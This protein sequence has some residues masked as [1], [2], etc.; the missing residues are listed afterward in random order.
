MVRRLIGE[1]IE[2]DFKPDPMLG[3]CRADPA[4]MEQVLINLAVNARDAM[5]GGGN[6]TIRTSNV[7]RNGEDGPEE[8][9]LVSV[10]DTGHG[11][12]EDTRA[13]IFEPFFTTKAQGKGTG[14]GLATVYG[15]VKQL[16]GYIWVHS[17]PDQGA[18]FTLHLPAASEMV[19]GMQAGGSVAELTER[20]ETILLVEDEDAVRHFSS[21]VLKR[22]GY[23]VIE[24][25]TPQEA[26]QIASDGR[27][28]DL[29][30]TDVVMPGLSG[31]DLLARLRERRAVRGLLMTGYTEKLITTGV[32]NTLVLEKPFESKELLQMVRHA[33]ETAPVGAT[34]ADSSAEPP[35][36]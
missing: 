18:S 28:L 5:P 22:H 26:L 15:I 2:L 33:L 11:M 29:V 27:H 1:D 9:V 7:V 24:A 25:A 30:L 34:V 36:G 31:P 3:A 13:R 21:R 20:D 12:D 6:L 32:G 10:R 4:Q 16:D 35:P 14:L 8:Y 17:A 23:Q 19:E